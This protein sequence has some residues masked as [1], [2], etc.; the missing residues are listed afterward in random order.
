MNNLKFI[1]DKKG[2][3][4]GDRA[5]SQTSKCIIS[6]ISYRDRAYRVGGYEFTLLI[7]DKITEDLLISITEDIQNILKSLGYTAACG[8]EIINDVNNF[9]QAYM[10]TDKKCTPANQL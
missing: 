5:L 2:H 8:Y 10:L 4:E 3:V 9:E 6:S 7:N 1:N